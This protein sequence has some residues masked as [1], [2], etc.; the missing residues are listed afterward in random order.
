MKISRVHKCI[1]KT[2]S[3][4]LYIDYHPDSKIEPVH[5]FKKLSIKL[6]TKLNDVLIF[7]AKKYSKRIKVY[8][9]VK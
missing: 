2:I 5:Y 4:V 7:I 1:F 6:A 9:L 8:I 3:Y